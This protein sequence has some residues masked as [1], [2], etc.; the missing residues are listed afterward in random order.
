MNAAYW[1][2]TAFTGYDRA[3]FWQVHPAPYRVAIPMVV[4]P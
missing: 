4:V 2:E 1:V 3:A